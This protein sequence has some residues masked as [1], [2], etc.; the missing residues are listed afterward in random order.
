MKQVPKQTQ[1]SLAFI[2]PFFFVMII[3]VMSFGIITPI[4]A[5][6][7]AKTTHSSLFG[8]MTPF[9]SHLI[10]GFILA[11]APC[12]YIFAAPFMGY[13]SDIFGRKRILLA[14]NVGSVIGLSTYLLSFLYSS[15]LLL[16]LGR[17]IV[18]STSGSL[19][20]AQSAMADISHHK[21]RTT[22]VAL[23]AV[24]MTIGLVSGP[25][26][27]G[28]LSDHHLF[29]GFGLTIP[30]YVAILLAL[31]N[32]IFLIVYLHETQTIAIKTQPN[33]CYQILQQIRT[34]Q[35][36]RWL[37][38]I[39]FIFEVS[40]SLYFQSLPLILIPYNHLHMLLARYSISSIKEKL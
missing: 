24:A 37:L 32:L 25:L 16:L 15:L 39:F 27:G 33:Q 29:W 22:N 21:K 14:C 1:P 23:I 5:S 6:L 9:T 13:L 10:Y 11:L 12:C 34:N 28:I 17:V 26:I 20:V 4:I 40:W 35:T 8:S 7:V 2:F 18:G 38:I 31:I 19:A 30:F 3:D 36:L